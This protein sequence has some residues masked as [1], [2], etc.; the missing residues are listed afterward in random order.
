M[1][2]A[3]SVGDS[4]MTAQEFRKARQNRKW[5]QQ[6]LAEKL[7]ISQGY[8]ALLERGKRG[9]SSSLSRKAIRVL[10]MNPTALP[11]SKAPFSIPSDRLA[12][13]LSALGYPGFRHLRS[14]RKRNPLEVLLG[15]LAQNNLEARVTEALP[16]LLLQYAEMSDANQKWLLGQARLQGLTNRLGFIAALAREVAARSGDTTSPRYQSLLRLEEDLLRSRLDREDT[17]CQSSLSLKEREWLKQSRP[18]QAETWHLLTDWLP[19][20]LQY[21]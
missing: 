7:G 18:P 6:K 3:Q 5:S 13:E 10:N 17:L 4:K 16:W 20:H 11:I 21:A 9:F 12:F 2:S 19:E 15:A 14:P 1:N 8:V